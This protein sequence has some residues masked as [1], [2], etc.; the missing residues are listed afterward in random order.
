M[1]FEKNPPPSTEVILSLFQYV[2]QSHKWSQN[3]NLGFITP[4]A[5]LN[6]PFLTRF[7]FESKTSISLPQKKDCQAEVPLHLSRFLRTFGIL[8]TAYVEDLMST[9]L[10]RSQSPSCCLPVVFLLYIRVFVLFLEGNTTE[11]KAEQ[12][13]LTSFQFLKNLVPFLMLG[14]CC[15]F[16]MLLFQLVWSWG[17]MAPNFLFNEPLQ[18]WLFLASRIQIYSR[19]TARWVEIIKNGGNCAG[20]IHASESARTSAKMFSRSSSQLTE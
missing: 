13:I 5:N 1:L 18:R 19:R 16:C 6:R 3:P 12:K 9:E 4:V 7:F 15:G 14:S 11:I 17:F 10:V 20:V 2:L 8:L